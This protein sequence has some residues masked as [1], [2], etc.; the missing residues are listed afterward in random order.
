MSDIFSIDGAIEPI[1]LTDVRTFMGLGEYD[2][3]EDV[4]LL[5]AITSC[6]AILE[7]HV[8]FWLASRTVHCDAEGP[9]VQ[10]RGPV[11]DLV[12]VTT[13]D[14]TDITDRCTL[15]DCTVTLPADAGRVRIE[16]LTGAYVPVPIQTALLIMVR[17]LITDR[18]SNPMTA[19][20]RGLCGPHIEVNI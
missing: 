2:T 18:A 7:Q 3:S 19:E 1:D 14:G 12:S 4:L 10:L 15:A 20:V 8:P 9:D 13:E 11:E 5:T 17:N 16:Y 6:R